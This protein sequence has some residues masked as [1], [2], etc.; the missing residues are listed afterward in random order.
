MG[1]YLYSK[2]AKL[3]FLSTTNF[4]VAHTKYDPDD[5]PKKEMTKLKPLQEIG[6]G[7]VFNN[8]G[9]LAYRQAIGKLKHGWN[10]GIPRRE[11]DL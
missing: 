6:I 4:C 3:F 2:G 1:N 8:N 9:E 7:L 10:V 5:V 11:K